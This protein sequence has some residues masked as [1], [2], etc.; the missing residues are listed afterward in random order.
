MK[1]AKE[2][3]RDARTALK[4]RWGSAVGTALVA[5]LLGGDLVQRGGGGS[6]S[7]SSSGSSVSSGQMMQIDPNTGNVYIQSGGQTAQV[8]PQIVS[9]I[10]IAVLAVLGFAILFRLLVGSAVEVGNARYNA[11]LIDGERPTIGTLFTGFKQYGS[12]IGMVVLRFVYTFLWS[13]LFIIPGIMKSYS[14]AMAPFVLADNPGMT[15][16]QA[17]TRS[18]EI[19]QG[20]RWRLFCLEISFIGWALLTVLTLGIGILWLNPYQNASRAAFYRELTGPVAAPAAET[21]E[22]AA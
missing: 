4:G 6:S 1:K 12:A 19:M 7:D 10:L 17:I 13:L 2:L 5:S 21:A 3:R 22:F 16:N 20:N 14:Y 15:A 18:K 9:I 11:R 8:D